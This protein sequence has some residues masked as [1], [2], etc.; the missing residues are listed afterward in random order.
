M[1]VRRYRLAVTGLAVAAAVVVAVLSIE[2]FPY[3]TSNHDEAVY[4]QQAA[5]LL[6]GQLVLDPPVPESFRP[7]F[8]VQTEGGQLYPKYSPVTAA[9]FAVGKLLGGYRI[10]LALV[11]AGVVSLTAHI[12]ATTWDRQTG[13]LAGVLLLGSPLFL[14]DSSVFLPYVPTMLWNLAFAAAYLR[15]DRT[16]SRGAGALAGI[17]VGVAFFA[18]P[19]T[20]VLFALPFIGHACWTLRSL[21]RPVLVRQGLTALFGIAGVAVALGYNALVTGDPLLFPY[22]V[23]A[24]Q[25]GLGF[26][27]REI[28]GYSR[29]YTPALALRSN[30]EALWVFATK[31]VVGGALGSLSAAV[32]LAISY[33]R[34]LTPRQSTIAGLFVTVP[35]GNLLFWGTLNTLGQL[36]RTGD[37][38][39]YYLG[40]YYHVDLLVPT[41][42]FG[43]IGLRWSWQTVRRRSESQSWIRARHVT[44]ALVLTSTVFAGVG[45]AM[46]TGPL[47]DN[48]AVTER[49]EQAYEPF[50]NRQLADSL[51]FLPAP[52]G[53]WIG[54]PFQALRNDP[55]FDG[56][57]VYALEERPFAVVDAYPERTLYRYTYRGPWAPTVGQTVEPRLQQVDHVRGQQI[58]QETAL[59]VPQFAERIS[60]RLSSANE[61]GYA[62]VTVTERDTLRLDLWVNETTAVLTGERI[63]RATVPVT[64]DEP[65]RLTAFVDYGTGAGFTYRFELPVATEN[66]TVR[67]LT[68]YT[69]VCRDARI[70]GGEAAYVPGVHDDGVS[71]DTTLTAESSV[72]EPER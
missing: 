66:G 65:V 27:H 60:L 62:T 20:A 38:L 1:N 17:T 11:A 55:G 67:A 14:V 12:V 7:W 28:L 31:W 41:V 44:A 42:A 6:E 61:S 50:E 71:V 26:G 47:A 49:Y 46:A 39:I 58:R 35:L 51:V 69:E 10:A 18:R 19:Y 9:M 56:E 29:A 48:A 72:T 25:D 54:H 5:M 33:R 70:C 40:P 68:P 43:A 57:T 3:H 30:A 15:A 4:L 21:D 13:L 32:G 53:D 2:L 8:F 24:P 59:G 64:D 52:Y 45:V 37:G 22:Q 63:E 23:F 16:G 34:G 36:D